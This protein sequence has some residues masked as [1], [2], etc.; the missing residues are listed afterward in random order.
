MMEL[1]DDNTVDEMEFEFSDSERED[2]GDSDEYPNLGK[3]HF[4]R[5]SDE[6]NARRKSAESFP[7]AADPLFAYYKSMSK[8]PLLTRE[9]EI[10]LAKRIESA[11]LNV[12]RVL[13]LTPITS[14]KT[15][16]MEGDLHPAE[17]SAVV[18]Q[19]GAEETREA[20]S[21]VS[22][23]ERSRIRRK[24]THKIIVR[25]QMLENRYRLARQQFQKR[26]PHN[27][28]GHKD[29]N[30]DAI[31]AVLQ[32]INFS[33]SQV[34]ELIAGLENALYMMEQARL[35]LRVHSK[36]QMHERRSSRNGHSQKAELEARYF[37]TV[38][39]L[40]SILQQVFEGRAEMA[41]AKDEFV[42]SNLR[43]VLSIAKT[44]SYPGMDPL[45]LI[46]E[47]N[48]GLMRAVDKFN[49]RFGYK[50][51]TYATWWIRQGITRAIADQGRTIRVPVHMVEAINR[52]MKVANELNKR[53]GHE[54]S[55]AE[56]AR[57]LNTPV[58]KLAQVLEAAQESVSLE[59]CTA[60]NKDAVLSKFIEDKN[61]V[62]PETPAMHDNLRAV[63]NSAL[64]L[65]SP[66]EQQIVRMRY[67]L[68]DSGKEFT[69]QEVGEVFQ[70]TRERIRQIEERALIKLRMRHPANKLREYAEFASEN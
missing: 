29:T 59:S 15:I 54:P 47:G 8:I 30:R 39:E 16:E 6:D 25:L 51:S 38:E 23:E 35:E 11:K 42:R 18:P 1:R 41:R 44:Y 7:H 21:E 26:N 45:D 17:I 27:G 34:S 46:Q 52:V 32:R 50:F 22:L 66:R 43:L 68:N 10:Y 24:L 67:G 33:E 57:R 48:I 36:R 62:S 61:A 9:Q 65:L 28:N 40:R 14:E 37:T 63:T 31:F 53:L 2:S 56:L 69:L 19:F 12:L 70:L 4:E 20:A 3:P 60:H 55:K 13:S 64:Q 5:N 58:A 49:Y